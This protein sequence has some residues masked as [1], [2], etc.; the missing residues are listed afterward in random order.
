MK[1]FSKRKQT[2]AQKT[3]LWLP[4]RKESIG[5]GQCKLGAWDQQIQA[6]IYKTDQVLP[7]NTGNHTQYFVTNHNGKGSKNRRHI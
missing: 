1:S 5:G 3:D 4:N 6:T 2:Q 7:C